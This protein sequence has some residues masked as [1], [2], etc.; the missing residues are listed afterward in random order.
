MPARP[1]PRRHW[2][3]YGDLPL[4]TGEQA[5]DEPLR[6]FPSWFLRIV[7]D[8]C[9][10]ERM[11]SETHMAQSEM[12]IRDILDRMRHDG[13]GGRVGTVELVT[14]IGWPLAAWA[15]NQV[16]PGLDSRQ[17]FPLQFPWIVGYPSF[18]GVGFGAD[19]GYW[20]ENASCHERD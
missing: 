12:L 17:P 20:V 16:E 7:C 15:P 6:A 19:R 9:G 3:C 14:V 4:P 11:I 1:V 10:K 5:L 2:R 18:V 8:R 13:C